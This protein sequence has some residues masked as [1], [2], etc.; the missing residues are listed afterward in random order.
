MANQP[1]YSF[2]DEDGN[3]PRTSFDEHQHT[4]EAF[5]TVTKWSMGIVVLILVLMAVFLL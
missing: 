2:T 3:P 1:T 5:L 4:Y